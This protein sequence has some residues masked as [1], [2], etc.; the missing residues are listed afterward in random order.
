MYINKIKSLEWKREPYSKQ[1]WGNNFHSISS[2]VGRIKPAFAHCLIES[3][4]KTGD[5]VYD[6]FC[7]IEPC[8]LKHQLWEKINWNRF[9]PLC[10]FNHK[11]KLDNRGLEKLNYLNDIDLKK[12]DGINLDGVE[13]WV[14]NIITLI[15]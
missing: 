8:L 3:V 11:S 13:D 14:K 1:N 6:P 7:G 4:S 2:Y 10:L 9:K 15:H 12:S 5:V